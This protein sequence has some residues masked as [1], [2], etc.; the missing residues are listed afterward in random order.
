MM[1]TVFKNFQV[2]EGRVISQNRAC[3]VLAKEK[4]LK[5]PK[6]DLILLMS[7]ICV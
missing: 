5:F 2:I 3:L 4:L 1:K 6:N 7:K